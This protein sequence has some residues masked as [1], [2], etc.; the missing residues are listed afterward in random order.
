[1]ARTDWNALEQ[2]ASQKME[3]GK[4]YTREELAGILTDDELKAVA[5]NSIRG[6]TRFSGAVKVHGKDGLVSP[7]VMYK[8]V[9][10][11]A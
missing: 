9:E 4:Y 1:M 5:R 11:G 2:S 8:L 6:R 3:A 7:I 10:G